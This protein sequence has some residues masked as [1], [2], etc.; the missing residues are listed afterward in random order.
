MKFDIHS[1]LFS[2]FLKDRGHDGP[3][4]KMKYWKKKVSDTIFYFFSILGFIAYV[5]SM[6]L[7]LNENLYSVAILDTLVYGVCLFFTFKKGFNYYLRSIVAVGICYVLGVF[8]FYILGPAGAGI[9]WLMGAIF[10]AAFLLGNKGS[11]I[12]FGLNT[13]TMG[14]FYAFIRAELFPWQ[15]TISLDSIAWGVK[16][17]NFIVMNLI[18]VVAN[19]IYLKGFQE[20]LERSN[21]TR[22]ATIFG[23]AKLAEYR[24]SDTGYHLNRIREIVS[25]IITEL[26]TLPQYKDYLS[27]GY[28]KDLSL[29]CTL[30]DI[31][32]V[33]IPDAI[34]LKPSSLTAEE[35]EVIKSHP[36][37]GAQVINEI[38]KKIHG[39]SF[40][41]LSKE[42]ALYHH[43]K[44]DGTGYPSRLKGEEIPL[45]ARITAIAD[46]YDALLSKRPYKEAF[47]QE[48]ALQII[49]DSRGT[50][51]DPVICD[52][53]IKAIKHVVLEDV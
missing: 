10:V 44:W 3:T 50:H 21:E 29:S 23:L 20:M 19:A 1:Y 48:K 49:Q 17:I 18:I 13:L 5:P 11:F 52:A 45:S 47:S 37:M 25:V 9:I 33:G 16:I 24:D 43:E 42:I 31:G 51:F 12:F 15:I 34:L 7:S 35:F 46:V 28:T 2:Y 32:K 4:Y 14:I 27:E 22:D 6:Y 36:E 53:F 38:E 8:L 26:A 30:H 39:H 40:Y 41:N